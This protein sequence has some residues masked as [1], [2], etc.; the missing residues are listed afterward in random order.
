[1]CGNPGFMHTSVNFIVWASYCAH[2][3]PYDFIHGVDNEEVPSRVEG[4]AD[5]HVEGGVGREPAIT[6]EVV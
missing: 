3:P 1:M 5:R 6:G 2:L 4:E